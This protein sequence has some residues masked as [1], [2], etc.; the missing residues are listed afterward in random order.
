M[1][2]V[3]RGL[4][5]AFGTLLMACIGFVGLAFLSALLPTKGRTQIP[6]DRHTIHVCAGMIHTDF[7][8]PTSLA[9]SSAF[10]PMSEHISR[11]LP[12]ESFVLMGWGDY[13]FFTEVPTLSDLRPGIVLGALTGRHETGVRLQPVGDSYVREYCRPLPLDA[14]GQTAI[15]E[16]IRG[17][18]HTSHVILG[19]NALG[20]T[21]L[22]ANKRY[23]LFQT[24]NDW[25]ARAMRK[26][27]LPAARWTAP[28]AFSVT[29]PLHRISG[30]ESLRATYSE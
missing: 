13:R 6:D 21:Y 10:T 15:A 1:H 30:D 22:K 9:R 7:A 29:W 20:P 23:G 28:F 25:T 5:W 17:T 11:T 18:L 4:K 19:A 27:G 2:L 26:A 12:E 16:H 14:D 24:C 8:V 3:G